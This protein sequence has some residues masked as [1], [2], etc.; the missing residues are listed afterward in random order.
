MI[1]IGL[2]NPVNSRTDVA[3]LGNHD[4]QLINTYKLSKINRTNRNPI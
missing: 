4:N 3:T 2:N 1:D